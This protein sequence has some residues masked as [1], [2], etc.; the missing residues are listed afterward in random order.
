MKGDG[1]RCS[2]TGQSP[3]SF[4]RAGTD[5]RRRS[6]RPTRRRDG[7]VD[8][9]KRGDLLLLSDAGRAWCRGAD[10]YGQIGDGGRIATVGGNAQAICFR[11]VGMPQTITFADLPDRIVLADGS[12]TVSATASSGLPGDV[13]RRRGVQRLH[14]VGLDRHAPTRTGYCS[15]RASVAGADGWA[16]TEASTSVEVDAD[17]D[18]D[19]VGDPVDNC[20]TTVN[21]G[22]VNTDHDGTGNHADTDDDADGIPDDQDAFPVT[23]DGPASGAISRRIAA[24]PALAPLL[25]PLHTACSHSDSDAELVETRGEGAWSRAPCSWGGTDSVGVG[26]P[27]LRAHRPESR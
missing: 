21:P 19:G 24:N 11:P 9:R 14:G 2:R 3:D 12:F 27:G 26:D 6:A 1:S 4:V 25:T 8:D 10:N 17:S 5:D 20:R 23:Q 22:Q 18:G 7:G 16:P 13:L 15:I